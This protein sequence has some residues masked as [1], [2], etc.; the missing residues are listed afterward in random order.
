MTFPMIS[1]V[2]LG[3]VAYGV[4]GFIAANFLP[5]EKNPMW[6][7]QEF[8]VLAGGAGLMGWP[9]L[10]ARMPTLTK[11]V[12]HTD[13]LPHISTAEQVDFEALNHLSERLKEAKDKDGLDLCKQLS[14]RVFLLHHGEVPS[15]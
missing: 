15:A 4:L 6:W 10:S 7:L 5:I 13:S 3:L 8:G 12:E 1:K 2:G 9:L 14:D 11:T